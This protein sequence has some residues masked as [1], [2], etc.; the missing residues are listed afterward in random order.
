MVR[1]AQFS[2]LVRVANRPDLNLFTNP[3]A[4]VS[5]ANAGSV[6]AGA[7]T[8]VTGIA[9]SPRGT[10]FQ[11]TA[12]AVSGSY[13]YVGGDS[14]AGVIQ[15]GMQPGKTYT[16]RGTIRLTAALGGTA[17]TM[18]RR[19]RVLVASTS[20][21]S[22][23]FTSPQAP[24]VAGDYD[25]SVTFTLPA[26]TTVA[27]V[28]FYHGHTA[29]TVQWHSLRLS[30][31][32][33][34][35]YF[36]GSD[37]AAL[38]TLTDAEFGWDGALGLSTS[39]RI[40]AGGTDLVDA[41]FDQ[42]SY[43][44]MRVP[45]IDATITL[46]YPGDAIWAQLD[47]RV[48]RDVILYFNIQHYDRDPATKL[49]NRHV[50]HLPFTGAV[51]DARGKLWLR[52]ATRDYVRDTITLRAS[53]GE[54][55]FEDKKRLSATALNTGAA[56][57]AALWEFALIDVGEIAAKGSVDAYAVSATIPAGDRRLWMQGESASSLFEDE[58]SSTT[59]P[60]RSYCS[61]RGK[62]GVYQLTQP[63]TGGAGGLDF[64]AETGD[65]GT[66]ISASHTFSRDTG[67]ADAT[68]VR[69]DYVDGAGVRQVA[70]QNDTAGANRAGKVRSI[71]RALP[72]GFNLAAAYTLEASRRGVSFRLSAQLDFNCKL[73]RRVKLTLVDTGQIIYVR[74]DN[75]TYRVRDGLM[76]V[77]GYI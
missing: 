67:W 61:D 54:V 36:D 69:A 3:C 28:R 51:H 30:E 21:G 75:I 23:S 34:T 20:G 73:E 40:A 2:T 6:S 33:Q 29:G 27:A 76:D 43:D 24:N 19:V 18:A 45:Y 9:T 39:W 77:N 37:N 46:P 31:G 17:D 68:L 65:N 32:T 62:F 48:A 12:S 5:L 4:E 35:D 52:E 72:G 22:V 16:A 42:I 74:P 10:A 64:L 58:L 15:N 13:M 44:R 26:D 59:E 11:M 14:P 41:E 71:N 57:A 70:Y 55:R 60:T 53:S 7:F 8:R 49:L 50:S 63:P 1:E 56:T 47:P 66:V 38:A 25:L